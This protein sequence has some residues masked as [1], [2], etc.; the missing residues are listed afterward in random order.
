MSKLQV[1][2]CL[3][4]LHEFTRWRRVPDWQG[5]AWQMRHC[6]R[7]GQSERRPWQGRERKRGGAAP[8]AEP[9]TPE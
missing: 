2:R 4:G 3:L 7:C 9:G 1:L 6:A 8:E 5:Q